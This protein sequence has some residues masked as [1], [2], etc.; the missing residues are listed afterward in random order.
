MHRNRAEAS[1]RFDKH[2]E[3][4]TWVIPRP[5]PARRSRS[6]PTVGFLCVEPCARL[7]QCNRLAPYSSDSTWQSVRVG[8][9]NDLSG[10]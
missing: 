9:P 5:A 3:R 1:V 4:L 10:L 6:S 8:S 7:V 2:G